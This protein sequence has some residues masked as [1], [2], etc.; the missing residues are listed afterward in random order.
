MTN[1]VVRLYAFAG[2]L[3]VLFL[4]W[5]TIA[6]KPWASHASA[7][8]D[9]RWTALAAR[10]HKLRHDAFVVQRVVGRRWRVYRVQ[11]AARRRAI[12]AA[13]KRHQN[14]LAAARAAAAA[15]SASLASAPSYSAPSSSGSSALAAPSVRVVTLP[16]VT[17]TRTS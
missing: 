3:L 17:I 14:Q 1:H 7:K 9:P 8:A 10:E 4:T 5:A 12:S 16:P 13:V 6:A 11:L 15:A 2:S